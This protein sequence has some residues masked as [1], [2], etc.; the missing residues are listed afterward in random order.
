M[1][2]EFWSAVKGSGI[3]AIIGMAF[4]IATLATMGFDRINL[5]EGVL[6]ASCSVFG[7]V[8]FGALIG[9]TGA[10]RKEAAPAAT[11]TAAAVGAPRVA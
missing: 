5:F 7:G 6:L 10:F 11:Q 8:L 4:G 1:S 3:G 2:K 9:I